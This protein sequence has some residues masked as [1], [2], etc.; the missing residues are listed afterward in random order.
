MAEGVHG[1]PYKRQAD[2]AFIEQAYGRTGDKAPTASAR[3]R[4]EATLIPRLLFG[5]SLHKQIA[6]KLADV[7]ARAGG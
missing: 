3:Q 5:H 1:R 2:G 4:T 7:Y 6:I